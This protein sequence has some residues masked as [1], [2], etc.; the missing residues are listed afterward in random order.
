MR[1]A[2]SEQETQKIETRTDEI[3]LF[4]R[5]VMTEAVHS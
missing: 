5:A 4:S 1:R 2:E 3:F